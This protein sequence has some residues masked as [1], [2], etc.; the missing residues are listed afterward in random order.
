MLIPPKNQRLVDM[1][2]QGV[3]V[4]V[5]KPMSE[6]LAALT[7]AAL[8]L[9]L[10]SMNVQA[11]TMLIKPELSTSFSRYE[12]SNNRMRVDVYQATAV[13]P[14]GDD[15]RFQVNGVKDVM[16]GASP[17]FNRMQ[18]GELVHVMSR[19]SISD[20]RDAVDINASYQLDSEINL[21]ATVGTSN[22]NDYSSNYFNLDSAWE[23]NQKLTKL[24]AGFGY[25][26]DEVWAVNHTPDIQ[27]RPGVGGDKEVWKGMLGI[28]Q[29]LDKDSLIQANITY[30]D[31]NGFLSDP[32][33]RVLVKNA[34]LNDTRPQSRQQVA[35]M[36]RYAHNFDV[37][38]SAAMHLDYRFYSDTWGV[39]AHTFEVA[40]HQP[41]GWGLQLTPRARYYSQTAADFYQPLFNQARADGFYSSDYRL[42]NFG[43]FNAGIQLSKNFFNR[44]SLIGAVDFYERKK[45]Y[46]LQDGAGTKIDDYTYAIYTA[47]VNLTF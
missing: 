9:P 39:D 43:S 31:N 16:S 1:E 4:A 28:T 8:A 32:Y 2:F 40:W 42:A 25:A 26:S 44:L 5:I 30:S 29:I 13:L 47:S 14:V 18:N 20:Q 36:L 11:D 27:R 24:N 17:I 3:V 34:R 41:L 38:N 15:L 19:A 10:L 35:L 23:F 7:Q 21:G 33:K 12:E 45:S 37:L 22:E 6:S 46:A